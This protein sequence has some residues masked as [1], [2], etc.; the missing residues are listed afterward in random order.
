MSDVCERAELTVRMIGPQRPECGIADYTSQLVEALR[1]L[2]NRIAYVTADDAARSPAPY[3]IV[4]IQHQ[5]FLFGGV[6]PWKTRFARLARSLRQA[7]VMTVHEI[8]EPEG[9]P[10]HQ[11]GVRLTNR[12]TFSHRAIRGFIVHT[13]SD[14]V[15]LSRCGVPADRIVVI[16]HGVPDPLPTPAREE[17]RWHLGLDGRF[18]LLMPGFLSRRKGH[19]VAIEA[20]RLLPPE[21]TLLI[22]GGRHPD[23]TTSYADEVRQTIDAAGLRERVRITGYLSASDL[24]QAYVASDLVLAPSLAESGSGSLALAFAHGRPIVASDIPAH[25]EIVADHPGSMGLFPSGS[26]AD[27]AAEIAAVGSVP[28]AR[29]ALA[30]GSRC[31]A[32]AHSYAEVARQTVALYD[33]VLAG[34]PLCG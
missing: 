27:L 2:V 3:D 20:L 23:D 28:E 26:A 21:W 25:G 1:P 33:T 18:V 32:M 16:R 31:Y 7:A 4:H 15:R 11:A 17:C 12:L 24:A 13:L 19:L 30:E 9:D 8:V 14:C 22:A 6:A 34:R 10:L 29:A 5:Y